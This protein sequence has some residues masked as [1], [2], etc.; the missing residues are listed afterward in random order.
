MNKSLVRRETIELKRQMEQNNDFQKQIV[1]S[2]IILEEQQNSEFS[3]D[4][5]PEDY[6][7]D[8]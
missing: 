2:E 8:L 1:T 5:N 3:S 4:D 7:D 6:F